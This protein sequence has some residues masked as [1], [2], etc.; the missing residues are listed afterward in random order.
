MSLIRELNAKKRK[1]AFEIKQYYIA[2]MEKL[3]DI[4]R[5]T[6]DPDA[7]AKI[8]SNIKY[9]DDLRVMYMTR[10]LKT[11]GEFDYAHPLKFDQLFPV[12]ESNP[13]VEECNNNGLKE[14]DD[15]KEG[16]QKEGVKA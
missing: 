16:N 5:N 3:Y 13:I 12:L 9:L 11:V 10:A 8:D 1:L 4:R 15:Q 7:V 6:K 2:E 14:K